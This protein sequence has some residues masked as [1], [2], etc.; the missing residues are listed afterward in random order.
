MFQNIVNLTISEIVGEIEN[1][2]EHYPHH[3]YQQAFSVPALRQELLAYV[4]SRI[5][6]HY[7]VGDRDSEQQDEYCSAQQKNSQSAVI[8]QGIQHIFLKHS[9]QIQHQVPETVS[10]NPPASHWFG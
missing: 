3:P 7:V 9:E 1:V 10:S 6:N 5:S 8:H 4:L 2:L